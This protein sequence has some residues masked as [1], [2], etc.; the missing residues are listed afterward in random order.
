MDNGE[1]KPKA[2]FVQSRQKNKLLEYNGYL[3]NRDRVRKD[4]SG[5]VKSYWGCLERHLE[6]CTCRVVTDDQGQVLSFISEHNHQA[7]HALVEKYQLEERVKKRIRLMPTETDG[8][9]R[10]FVASELEKCSERLREILQ[11]KQFM[12]QAR[13]IR[14]RTKRKEILK[15]KELM[16]KIAEMNPHK[17]ID[18]R[19]YQSKV[20]QY[21]QPS[22]EPDFI[23]SLKSLQPTN[24]NFGGFLFM[25]DRVI[26]EKHYWRCYE[27][28]KIKCPARLQTE[29]GRIISQHDQHNH[30]SD[31]NF[32]DKMKLDYAMRQEVCN[33]PTRRIK[34]VIDEALQENPHLADLYKPKN[35]EHLLCRVRKAHR[36]KEQ[37]RN[38]TISFELMHASGEEII[39]KADLGE[40]VEIKADSGEEVE[41]LRQLE[42]KAEEM[43]IESS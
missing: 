6:K 42:I 12:A 35:L 39:I 7:E 3:F 32:I 17:R 40:E 11:L 16:K 31:P 10:A 24:I 37:A 19:T 33:N 4:K 21:F 28:Q 38:D 26:H 13:L 9:F 34:E 20:V 27:H 36:L 8:D 22:I 14:K 29:N 30:Q 1:D 23:Y 15:R 43:E 41:P 18:P 5:E 25:R 2:N